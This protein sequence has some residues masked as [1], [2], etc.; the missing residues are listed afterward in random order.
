[1]SP[2]TPA[3][4]AALVAVAAAGLLVPAGAAHADPGPYHR[5]LESLAL[6]L[7]HE[8]REFDRQVDVNFRF[9]PEYERLLRHTIE[10]QRLSRHI[11]EEARCR[12][13]V[14]HLRYDV[15]RLEAL[16][17]LVRTEVEC[18]GR[19]REVDRRAYFRLQDE[20]DEVGL[21]LRRLDRELSRRCEVVIIIR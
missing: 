21:A 9:T 19:R 2:L 20:L 10:M 15:E 11:A 8:V 14:R 12:R 18:L 1:M 4:A 17:G 5:D 13:D 3:R 6:R 7:S 16:Y